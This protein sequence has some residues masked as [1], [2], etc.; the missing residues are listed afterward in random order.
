MAHTPPSRLQPGEIIE[1]RYRIS[2]LVHAEGGI[3][4]YTAKHLLMGRNV[5]LQFLCGD[6]DGALR[7]FR[8]SGR[9]LS[10]MRHPHIVGIHDMGIYDR[11]PYMAL[12]YLEGQTLAQRSAFLG[13]FDLGSV[14]RIAEQLLGAVAY[15]H[16]RKIYHRD[17]SASNLKVVEM[18]NG[19][20]AL[21]L[22]GFAFAKDLGASR[23]SSLSE[24]RSMVASLTHVAPEQILRPDDADYRVDLYASGAVLYQL[25]AGAP[26]FR[27]GTLAELGAAIMEETPRSLLHYVQ[28]LPPQLDAVIAQALAKDPDHR[29]ESADA[30]LRAIQASVSPATT[31]P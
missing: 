24:K 1:G 14:L 16:E 20:E 15:V 23:S 8:R 22:T 17:I 26:P 10:M 12:E 21:K 9:M 27:G 31:P 3:A 6:T 25:I 28:T 2:Q 7:R 5:T 13:P 11:F 18:W 4:T 29:F 19:E 30:M